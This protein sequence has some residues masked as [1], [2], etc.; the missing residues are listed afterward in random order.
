MFLW[1]SMPLSCKAWNSEGRSSKIWRAVR[2]QNFQSTIGGA[3]EGCS[4]GDGDAKEAV[5]CQGLSYN[6]FFLIKKN[7]G[8]WDTVEYG[9]EW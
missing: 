6:T 3:E 5:I 1:L 2:T 7:S 9:L 4:W 8:Q